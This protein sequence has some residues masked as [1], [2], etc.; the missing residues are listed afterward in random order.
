MFTHYGV[1]G[2]AVFDLSP[3]AVR[4][5]LSSVRA[6]LS[7]NFFP[8]LRP[9]EVEAK[10]LRIWE[11][12]PTRLA[13]NTLMGI[14]P[15][16]LSQVLMRTVAGLDISQPASNIT[17][18]CRQELVR[19]LTGLEIRLK[20]SCEFKEAQVTSGGVATDSVDPKTMES[21]LCTGLFFC[22]EVLDIDGDCGGFNLQFAF[23]SGRAAGIAAGASAGRSL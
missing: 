19:R 1:S 9:D 11:S 17:K 10:I 18:A 12:N 16:K 7:L 6:V 13:A 5:D 23:S 21:K 14:L 20:K 2:P 22:G 3:Y 15:K 8:G 4:E